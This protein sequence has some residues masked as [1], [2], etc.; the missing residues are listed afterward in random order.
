V[1]RHLRTLQ[2]HSYHQTPTDGYPADTPV[3]RV[4]LVQIAK[5]DWAVWATSFAGTILLGVEAGL[6]IAI[7]LALLSV[8][9]ESA[10]PHTAVLGNLP[11]TRVY[12]WCP[13]LKHSTRVAATQEKVRACKAATLAPS[14]FRME[15]CQTLGFL[16]AA[17]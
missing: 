17:L 11:G 1:G 4:N 9:Y 12:R 15:D 16:K 2:Q 3:S 13:L 7:A 10:F 14:M 5:L 6:G 8:I